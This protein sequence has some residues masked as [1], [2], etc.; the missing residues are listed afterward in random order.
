VYKE[1]PTLP[2]LKLT[3]NDFIIQHNS[4]ES[5]TQQALPTSRKRGCAGTWLSSNAIASG[6]LARYV[7]T[8]MDVR[9]TTLVC[10]FA[11]AVIAK[12]MHQQDLNSLSRPREIRTGG[13][14]LEKRLPLQDGAGSQ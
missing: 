3:W 13:Y 8:Q 12:P 5:H 9:I 14:S 1:A 10:S 4:V 11:A 2:G 6:N 7:D